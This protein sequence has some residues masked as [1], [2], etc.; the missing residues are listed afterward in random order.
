M[1]HFI[2]KYNREMDHFI[3]KYNKENEIFSYKLTCL[4][5]F[6]EKV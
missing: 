5:T 6:N 2:H 4:Q 1:D 3:H